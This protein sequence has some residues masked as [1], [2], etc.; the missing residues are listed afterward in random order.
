MIYNTEADESAKAN[1]SFLSGKF[2]SDFV[3]LGLPSGTL[4]ARKNLLA[5]EECGV[6]CYFTF[7]NSNPYKFGDGYVFNSTNYNQTA[8]SQLD[9]NL[10]LAEDP[11][12]AHLGSKWRLPTESEFTELYNSSLLNRAWTSIDDSKGEK[13]YGMK[14]SSKSDPTKWIFLPATGYTANDELESDSAGYYM[15]STKSTSGYSRV[16][17]IVQDGVTLMQDFYRYHGC[18]V[19]PVM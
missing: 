5:T 7:G 13:V 8:G 1:A 6:G 9:A 10:T 2:E 18:V 17:H 15:V 11:A 14:F 12:R 4:W 3:D 16:A 19:R